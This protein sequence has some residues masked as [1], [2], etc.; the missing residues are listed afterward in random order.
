MVL[1]LIATAVM[2]AL[3]GTAHADIARN[4]QTASF[5]A[6]GGAIAGSLCMPV[7]EAKAVMVLTSGSGANAVY[8]DFPYQPEVYSFARA[9]N[10]A[11]YATLALDRLGNGQ[12]STPPFWT[13]TASNDAEGVHT[14][15]QALR[16]GLAGLGP[17]ETVVLGG[18]A[19]GSGVS[20]LESATYQ[21]V[22]GVLLT[23]YSHV[24]DPLVAL[25]SAKTFR[26]APDDPAFRGSEAGW[27]TLAM[28]APEAVRNFFGPHDD[29]AVI[30]TSERTKDRFSLTE[31]P[32]GLVATLPGATSHISV[33]VLLAAGSQDRLGCGPICRD[34]ATLYAV[35]S[36]F[37]S[38]AAQLRT[39]VLHDGGDMINLS[40]GAPEYQAAVRDW[41]D[42][43]TN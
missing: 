25:D 13:V 7:G 40:S 29:P 19:L 4:C 38:P 17:F 34:A 11:G 1:V 28:E 41:M 26:H 15:V 30:E 14:A 6:P 32:D 42:W 39:Y 31:W 20:V 35:E 3:S 18:N 2:D 10:S 21:D 37:Y 23:G 27:L 9:M 12:S 8:W 33:P 36:Q 16:N 22:D 5:T 24:V 43:L